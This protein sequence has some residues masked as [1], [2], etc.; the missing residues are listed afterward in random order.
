VRDLLICD[1]IVMP[2]AA[3][4]VV[5]SYLVNAGSTPATAASEEE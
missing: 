2:K 3:I 1:N 4:A 5:E